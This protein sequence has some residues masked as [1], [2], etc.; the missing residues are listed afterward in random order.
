MSKIQPGS[1]YGFTS[2][3]YG[4]T[5]NT[6]SPFPSESEVI[7]RLP[8][9]VIPVGPSGSNFRYQ[10]VSGTLNNLVPKID[11]VI[12]STEVLL[13]RTTSGVPD[14]P[15]GQ[16]SI[17]SSTLESW[18][19]LRSGPD[20]SSP[21]AFPDPNTANAAYP[22]VISSNVAL[23]DTDT[24][25]YVLLAKFEMDSSTAPTTGALYQY[26]FGSLWGDRIKLGTDTAQYYYARI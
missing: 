20:T 8:F 24:Y 17:S 14:P 15:T 18:I 7:T 26:V 4:F 1:G 25:G 12:T 5:I 2:G 16:L 13:D 10:V 6:T 22:K 21:Y 19:Y 3:G 11:D 23:T 9:K